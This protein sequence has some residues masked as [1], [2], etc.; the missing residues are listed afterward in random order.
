MSWTFTDE[1][2]M[3]VVSDDS[4]LTVTIYGADGE[5]IAT[6]PYSDEE[7]DAVAARAAAIKAEENR[8][9]L[10]AGLKD[11][12]ALARERQATYQTVLNT[13]NSEVNNRPAPHIMTVAR[14]GKR[15]ERAII[16]LAR[17]A[18]DILDSTDTGED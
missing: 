3:R 15:S 7:K 11:V 16:R 18:G 17:L 4:S 14:Q 9:A 10:R 5:V 2:G 13:P 1:D 12:I 6:R 8:A